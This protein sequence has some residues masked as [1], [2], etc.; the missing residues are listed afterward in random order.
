MVFEE[1][2]RVKNQEL[3]QKR[4]WPIKNQQKEK[5]LTLDS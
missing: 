5:I 2:A 1:E 4:T 3:R